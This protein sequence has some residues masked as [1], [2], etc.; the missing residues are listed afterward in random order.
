MK[1]KS[2]V[3]ILGAT[4]VA[5]GHAF[6]SPAQEKITMHSAVVDTPNDAFRLIDRINVMPDTSPFAEETM[7]SNV[8]IDTIINLGKK[9]WDVI[10][11]NRP[12]ANVNVSFANALPKG[13]SNAADLTGFSDIQN[14]SIRIW[15][16]NPYGFTVYD[17]T[18]TAIHQYGG[19]FDGK[20]QYLSTVAIV[21]SHVRVLWGYTVNY[22]VETV[23]TTNLG[24]KSDPISS[25]ALNAKFKVETVIN[26]T[27]MNTVYQFRGDSPQVKT[28]GI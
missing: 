27:E 18:L 10:K 3:L 19:S 7:R 1:L 5:A 14:H 12:V 17:V 4:F 25:I 28:S 15:G 20:G 26:K 16:T 13:V 11:A 21:P 8:S 6:A 24:T 2:M 23:S 9:A 22:S